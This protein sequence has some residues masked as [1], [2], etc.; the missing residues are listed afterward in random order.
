MTYVDLVSPGTIDEKIL[1]A[2][3]DKINIAG[4]VLGESAKDWLMKAAVSSAFLTPAYSISSCG[5]SI[6]AALC[7]DCGFIGAGAGGTGGIV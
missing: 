4:D 2:L 1:S 6:C 7:N 5:P 3:R